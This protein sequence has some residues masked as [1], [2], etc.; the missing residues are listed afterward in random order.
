MWDVARWLLPVVYS[1]HGGSSFVQGAYVALGGVG[2]CGWGHIKLTAWC[3]S[4]R[5]PVWVCSKHAW[6]SARKNRI[7]IMVAH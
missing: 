3:V 5:H 7:R 1:E 2:N 4:K 6:T